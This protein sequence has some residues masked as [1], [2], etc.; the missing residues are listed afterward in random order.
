MTDQ[1]L[2]FRRR[3]WS[4]ATA[5]S[6]WD[7]WS[8]PVFV[9][10]EQRTALSVVEPFDEWEEFMLFSSHYF[11]L[12]ATNHFPKNSLLLQQLNFQQLEQS[13]EMIQQWN[14]ILTTAHAEPIPKS[15]ARRFG[16]LIP[17]SA[18]I[19]GHY[20]GLGSQTRTGTM[21]LYGRAGAG[22]PVYLDSLGI[23]PR[24]CHTITA[25]DQD[26]CLLVGGR[27]S[28]DCPLKDCWVLRKCWHRVDDLPMALFRHCATQVEL[29]LIGQKHT[30]VLI[31][32]GK[33]ANDRISD[34][35]LLWRENIG[36]VQLAA[37]GYI[38]RPRFGAA[39][40]STS[41]GSGLLLGG[42]N[43]DGMIVSDVCE[44]SV[45]GGDKDLGI[46]LRPSWVLPEFAPQVKGD[47][48][49]PLLHDVVAAPLACN[50]SGRMGACLVNSPAGVM[51]LG[52]VAPLNL[53]QDLDVVRLTKDGSD[54]TGINAW[55]A[56]PLDV[57]TNCTRPLLVGHTSI[58]F[59]NN[60]VIVGGGAV[61]FSFGTYCNQ[62]LITISANEGEQVSLNPLA[63]SK[64]EKSLQHSASKEVK[65]DSLVTATTVST[66]E[67]GRIGSAEEFERLAG[68]DRPVIFRRNKLGSC[69]TQ[70]TMDS[71]KAKV[72]ANRV[73]TFR[74]SILQ[75]SN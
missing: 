65:L 74:Q 41:P 29:D 17:V 42:L 37:T 52:G 3:G 8:D 13:P 75:S 44:W 66:V 46:T 63:S 6:L 19:L 21:D 62:H 34:K 16:A 35:W 49:Q 64:A 28:P 24:M 33:S 54:E 73:V 68:Q 48:T 36:W 14:K 10:Q 5:R 31:Y 67:S 1:E 20:G 22:N 27:T 39:M 4:S 56:T 53:R 23:Q 47:S 70:W 30:S 12:I 69:M 11:L 18:D 9:S 55:L 38:L 25:V 50:I 43:L 59:H 32:G 72:G 58:A 71:L 26:T 15:H 51:L 2:R 60:V 40:T 45:T 57:Q 7:I 61:C